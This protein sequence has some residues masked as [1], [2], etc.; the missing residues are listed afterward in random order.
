MSGMIIAKSSSGI[1]YASPTRP[2]KMFSAGTFEYDYL[3]THGSADFPFENEFL[4]IAETKK[5]KLEY[6]SGSVVLKS[7]KSNFSFPVSVANELKRSVVK[8]FDMK[9]FLYALEWGL[10]DVDKLKWVLS[11]LAIESV[12]SDGKFLVI[13]TSEYE[14][15]KELFNTEDGLHDLSLT[16][17]VS[18]N[19]LGRIELDSCCVDDNNYWLKDEYDFYAGK[20]YGAVNSNWSECLEDMKFE[21]G[22]RHYLDD[23]AKD[24]TYIGGP[25]LSKCL[26]CFVCRH[27]HDIWVRNQEKMEETF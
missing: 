15:T 21:F 6:A 22:K 10:I 27:K 19:A 26:K 9:S 17:T 23:D 11:H 4:T 8:G 16:M 18:F 12:Y 24:G 13:K 5:F 7:L 20:F 14:W 2:P 1:L 25:V 3:L